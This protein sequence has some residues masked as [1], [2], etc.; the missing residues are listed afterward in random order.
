MAPVDA[1]VI[2]DLDSASAPRRRRRIPPVLREPLTILSLLLMAAVVICALFADTIGGRDPLEQFRGFELLPPLAPAPDGNPFLLGSDGLGRDLWSRVVH[3]ARIS[4]Y[5]SVT[6]TV[7]VLIVGTVVGLLAGYYG[8]WVD[9]LLQRVVDVFMA[10]PGIVLAMVIASV[11]RFGINGV[12]LAILIIFWPRIARVTRGDVLLARELGY[13]EAARAEGCRDR[14]ILVRHILPN[15]MSSLIVMV[16]V[17]MGAAILTEAALAFLTIGATPPTPSWGLMIADAR[18]YITRAPH[19][20]LAPAIPL[21]LVV[22]ALNL[23]GDALR[24]HLDPRMRGL[25]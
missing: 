17:T 5:V 25:R 13:V 9:A 19:L 1:R 4:I 24:D 16:T 18:Q 15:V 6:A 10:I 8:G 21:S 2:A 20:L 3:G 23:G 7:G 14:L 22:L 11:L 12:I